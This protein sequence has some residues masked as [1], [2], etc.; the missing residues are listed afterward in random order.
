MNDSGARW[1][2][3][4]P[5]DGVARHGD[6]RG[7]EAVFRAIRRDRPGDSEDLLDRFGQFAYERGLN[8]RRPPRPG[9]RGNLSY[10]L[11]VPLQDGEDRAEPGHV[12]NHGQNAG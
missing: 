2:W 5:T 3:H 9:A 10:A 11:V 8:G 4:V 1:P 6:T 12:Q 7:V